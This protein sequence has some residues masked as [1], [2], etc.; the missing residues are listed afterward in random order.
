MGSKVKVTL[1]GL[2]SILCDAL[3]DAVQ[4]TVFTFDTQFGYGK[5]KTPIDFG[6]MGSKVTLTTSY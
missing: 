4:P 6:V 1:I 5:R 2:H 3:C